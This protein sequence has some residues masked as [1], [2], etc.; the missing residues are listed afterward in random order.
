MGKIEFATIITF[1]LLIT[2]SCK[3]KNDNLNPI[4]LKLDRFEQEFYGNNNMSLKDLKQKYPYLFPKQFADSIWEKQ[5]KDS[6]L[7]DIYQE[8]QKIHPST[9]SIKTSIE[10]LATRI[11]KIDST[12]QIQKI[13][14][15]ISQ[16]DRSVNTVI[17]DSLILISLDCFLGENHPYYSGFPSYSRN[18]LNTDQILPSLVDD[19][20]PKLIP[21]QKDRYFISSMIFHGKKLYLKDILLPELNDWTK[22][23]YSKTQ[24]QWAIENQTYIWSYFIERKMLYS[25]DN[26]LIKRFIKEAPFSKFY[27][28]IDRE[29][30][31]RIG[32]WIGW[33]IVKSFMK[34]NKTDLQTMLNTPAIEIFK[35]CGYKPQN[36]N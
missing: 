15:V 8:V 22:I 4:K 14:T 9:D 26:K 3:D 34:H 36:N 24:H 6:L 17:K 31:G 32:Q 27:K 12:N 5:R 18:R 11:K 16:V 1:F 19:Y 7:L 10:R 2:I 21:N 30:P 25:T 28:E 29:S 23:G 20:A 13:V 35:S 33:Q